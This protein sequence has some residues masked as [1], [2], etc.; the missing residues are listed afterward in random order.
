METK[1][2]LIQFDLYLSDKLHTL[3]VIECEQP[4]TDLY[5]YNGRLELSAMYT[6]DR[7]STMLNVPPPDKPQA[8]PLMTENILLRG[9]RIK[10]TDWAIGCAVYTGL[11]NRNNCVVYVTTRIAA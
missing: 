1:K 11:C 4:R 2:N 3:G 9:S 6:K 10:N 5:T 8:I 7:H